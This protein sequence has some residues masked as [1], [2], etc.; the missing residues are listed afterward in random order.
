MRGKIYALDF[1]EVP[2]GILEM[3]IALSPTSPEAA[4]ANLAAEAKGL[5]QEAARAKSAAA[6]DALLG[7]VEIDARTPPDVA[8]SF[9][10]AL[11]RALY[12][13]NDWSDVG[14]APYFT[15][16]SLWDTF[17]A[18]HPLYTI[19][20]PEKVDG[21][22][23]SMLRQCD[24]QGYLPIWAVGRSD[25]HCMIGHHAVPVIVDAYLKG[26]RG[27]DP[28]RAWRAVK[29]SLTMNHHPVGDGTWGL[30]KEDWDI[31]DKYGYYPFDKMR[32]EYRGRGLV[33]GESAARTLECAY[34]DACA[35]RFA[36]AL[37]KKDDAAFFGRRDATTSTL[38]QY[39]EGPRIPSTR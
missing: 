6:W 30:L 9:R 17:R 7:R 3:R 33:R 20:A 35:A 39:S 1:G 38:R 34:D 14:D 13:P 15:T 8:A 27:F 23:T 18:A 21:F 22:V 36:A 24:E 12:Q 37:G 2:D 11:M 10:A 4:E 31:L 16:L 25:N 26:F 5:A 28:E 29:Q 32:G 19:V